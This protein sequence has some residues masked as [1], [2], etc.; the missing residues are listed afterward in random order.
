MS[1]ATLRQQ[2]AD[3]LDLPK[4]DA[5]GLGTGVRALDAVLPGEGVPRGR[6]TEIIGA[7]GSGKTT[8]VRS[9]VER[10]VEDGLW[11]A[12]VDASRT[13]APRD[14]A[15]L[16]EGAGVWMI[17]PRDAAR[18]PWC[19]D[20]LLRSGAFALVVL[21]SAPMLT[22]GIAV[23][24]TRLARDSNAA[25]I[26]I[27][28]ER[29]SSMV[30]GSLRL[31]TTGR[32]RRSRRAA[33]AAPS[34]ITIT[35]EKGGVRQS[36]EV[37]CGIGMARRLC[38]HPEVPDRRGVAERVRVTKGGS[39]DAVAAAAGVIDTSP[40]TLARKRRCAEPTLGH[41]H[42]PIPRALRTAI[43]RARGA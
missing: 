40:P 8:F 6:L 5:P 39:V 35:V 34:A 37:S 25:L 33:S 36:V 38:S 24:L 26:A 17:R 13:L 1:L 23:R 29:G 9:I 41:D 43:A 30:P 28:D 20:V 11:V 15:H 32:D 10:A 12:Y 19:A 27:G 2:L 3:V 42:D 18:A 21:D 16:G 14:W 22:R 4:P 7:L 31:K